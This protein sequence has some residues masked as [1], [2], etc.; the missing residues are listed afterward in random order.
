MIIWGI[1]SFTKVNGH[2]SQ[3]CNFCKVTCA[4]TLV[5]VTRMFTV[6]FIPLIPLGSSRFSICTSCASR[7]KIQGAQ[8]LIVSVSQVPDQ[9]RVNPDSGNPL[10]SQGMVTNQREDE[11][12]NAQEKTSL[13]QKEKTGLALVK[14]NKWLKVLIPGLLLISIIST[15]LVLRANDGPSPSSIYTSLRNWFG[16]K[17]LHVV[18]GAHDLAKYEPSIQGASAILF[19]GKKKV[20]VDVVFFRTAFD[21][22]T[23]LNKHL[24]G[25]YAQGSALYSGVEPACIGKGF[26][27]ILAYPSGG[28]SPTEGVAINWMT[29]TFG[30][31]PNTLI[32]AKQSWTDTFPILKYSDFGRRGLS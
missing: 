2:K 32:T 1:R 17:N 6:F 20:E 4:H 30:S 27:A 31:V 21:E 15:V 22:N 19:G 18:V 9:T 7:T 10:N 11:M 28:T 14:K 26:I 5:V 12:N 23:F 3:A 29:S 16:D 13:L 25:F 24:G 8:A